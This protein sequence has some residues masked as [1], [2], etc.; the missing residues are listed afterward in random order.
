MVGAT[1]VF[2]HDLDY[3]DAIQISTSALELY[4]GYLKTELC[5]K[6]DIQL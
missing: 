2:L 1:G 5:V 4:F 3:L 6:G